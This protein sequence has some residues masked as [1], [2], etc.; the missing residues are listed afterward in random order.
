[1]LDLSTDVQS[2]P[3]GPEQLAQVNLTYNFRYPEL[4]NQQE[5]AYPRTDLV[6][7]QLDTGTAPDPAC[8]TISRDVAVAESDD[9]D[10]SDEPQT[11]NG[12]PDLNTTGS[13]AGGRRR[14][15]QW[16]ITA[17][18]P[19]NGFRIIQKRLDFVSG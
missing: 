14:I 7:D 1:M 18:S 4:K 17:V 3:S 16:R 15:Y 10:E 19:G 11:N 5:P 2:P 8:N 6:E 9:S 13:L 12:M